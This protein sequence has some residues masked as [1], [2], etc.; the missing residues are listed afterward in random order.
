MG[1]DFSNLDY[2]KR[3]LIKLKFGEG[4]DIKMIFNINELFTVNLFV[5]ARAIT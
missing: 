1:I 4:M 5:S 3:N 2:K